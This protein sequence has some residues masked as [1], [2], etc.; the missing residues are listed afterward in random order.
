MQPS[1]VGSIVNA[2]APVYPR[3]V[4]DYIGL[5]LLIAVVGDARTA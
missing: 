1:G 2:L 4:F 5:A 3:P